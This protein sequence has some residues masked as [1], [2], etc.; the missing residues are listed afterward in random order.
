MCFSR[1]SINTSLTSKV[2]EY[3]V[4]QKEEE[5]LTKEF[6]ERYALISITTYG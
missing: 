3:K 5:V 4:A 1:N 2:Y 6:Y